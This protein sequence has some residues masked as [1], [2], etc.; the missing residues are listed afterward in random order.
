MYSA[1]MPNNFLLG[2]AVAVSYTHLSTSRNR[3]DTRDYVL[4]DNNRF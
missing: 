1:K 4:L 2:G 3:Y